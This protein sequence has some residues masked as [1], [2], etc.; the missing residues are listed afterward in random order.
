MDGM[1][2][3]T[4]LRSRANGIRSGASL[5]LPEQIGIEVNKT[6]KLGRAQRKPKAL[7]WEE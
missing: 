2:K 3:F 4:S 5:N 1:K 7:N 6:S